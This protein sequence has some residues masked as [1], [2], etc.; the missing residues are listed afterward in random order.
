M[1]RL[2][3]FENDRSL[4]EGDVVLFLKSEK[5]FQNIYQYGVVVG[6]MVSKDGLIRSAEIKFQNHSENIKRRT[7]RGV[8]EIVV[9]HPVDDIGMNR[10]LTDLYF[11]YLSTNDI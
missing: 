4:S 3:W 11:A 10:E 7:T 5:E 6:L 2:K 1:D 9:I 8:R